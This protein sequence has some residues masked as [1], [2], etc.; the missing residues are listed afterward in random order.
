MTRL[1]EV[2]LTSDLS[3]Q[4]GETLSS[5]AQLMNQVMRHWS[6]PEHNARIA[7]DTGKQQITYQAFDTVVTN[8]VV[9]LNQEGIKKGDKVAILMPREARQIASLLAC[10][11]IGAIALML[12]PRQP[13]QRLKDLVEESNTT[14]VIHT[15]LPSD[16]S[17]TEHT[18]WLLNIKNGQTEG[19]SSLSLAPWNDLKVQSDETTSAD[20]SALELVAEGMVFEDIAPEDIA[21][22]DIAYILYTSGSTGKPKGVLVSHGAL[23]HYSAAISQAVPS[24]EGGRWLT[25]ATV[26][27]DL[28]LTSVLAALY[29]G[30]TLLLPEEELAFNP[31]ELAEFLRQHPADYLKIVPSHLKGLLSVSSPIDILPKRALISGG[32]GMDEV[33]LNQLHSLASTITDRVKRRSA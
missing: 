25:L 13:E 4:L 18:E 11:R 21:P 9:Q 29:Q 30:Q 1:S 24:V 3:R 2:A 32:E 16:A 26:A 20:I 19:V 27:A 22:E 31:P 8:L 7:L 15:L 28:G 5:K 6:Q 12:D 10:W 33:L 17:Y 14:L 23:A